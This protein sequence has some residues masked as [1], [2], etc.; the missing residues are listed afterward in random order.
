M[1]ETHAPRSLPRPLPAP[2]AAPLGY[3]S[4]GTSPTIHLVGAGPVGRAFLELLPQSGCRLIAVS[5]SRATVHDRAGLPALELAAWKARGRSLAARAGAEAL[6][7]ETALPLIAAD[8]VVDATPSGAATAGAALRRWGAAL[9]AGSALAL[10]SKDGV[11]AGAR[12]LL[13]PPHGARVGIDAVL[14]G[15]GAALLRERAEL[16]RCAEIVLVANV[17]TTVLVQALERGLSFDDGVAD[18]QRRGL[19]ESDPELDLDG[20]DALTKLV[21]VAGALFGTELGRAAVTRQHARSLE[22]SLVRERAARGCTTRLVGRATR[23][24]H[25]QV[26]YEEVAPGSP[27]FAPADRVVYAYRFADDSLRVHVGSGLGP[28]GTATALFADVQR[29]T[30]ARGGAS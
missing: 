8:V 11:A 1:N 17:T 19:L 9:R 25:L 15:A 4:S 23:D 14:G 13:A 18:A 24:G 6:P 26:A 30:A 28:A 20:S 5:D 7:L 22:P 2:A 12:D 10:A 3:G 29:L 27:W 21:I 16:A